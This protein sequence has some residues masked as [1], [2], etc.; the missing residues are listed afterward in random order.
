MNCLLPTSHCLLSNVLTRLPC[1][2]K[3]GDARSARPRVKGPW[4]GVKLRLGRFY[5]DELVVAQ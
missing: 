5:K 3:G 2:Q 1:R 4:L